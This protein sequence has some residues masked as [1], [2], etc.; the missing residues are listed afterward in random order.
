MMVKL[1][2]G[3]RTGTLAKDMKSPSTSPHFWGIGKTETV[4]RTLPFFFLR[5][6]KSGLGS[7]RTPSRGQVFYFSSA[8]FIFTFFNLFTPSIASFCA[9]VFPPRSNGSDIYIHTL[10]GS[11]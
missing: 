9:A 7:G 3:S 1:C 6:A 10:P 5:K 8:F 11:S 2:A 4:L